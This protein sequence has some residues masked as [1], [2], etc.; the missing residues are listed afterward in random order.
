MKQPSCV[1]VY[2][3]I[4]RRRILHATN[5]VTRR[6]SCAAS[7]RHFT[8][9]APPPRPRGLCARDVRSTWS[10]EARARRAI[11]IQIRIIFPPAAG[12]LFTLIVVTL[13]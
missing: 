9:T 7:R 8:Y 3:R 2:A 10:L 1:C 4:C 5:G 6:T 11:I 13:S 12:H